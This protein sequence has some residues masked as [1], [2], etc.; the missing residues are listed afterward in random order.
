MRSQFGIGDDGDKCR[1]FPRA[2]LSYCGPRKASF[3][4][5]IYSMIAAG[6]LPEHGQKNWRRQVPQAELGTSCGLASR[7]SYTRRVSAIA[8]DPGL[9]PGAPAPNP[10]YQSPARYQRPSLLF[11]ARQFGAANKY[12][13]GD[14]AQAWQMERNPDRYQAPSSAELA[15]DPRTGHLFSPRAGRTGGFKDVPRWIFDARLPLNDTARM[16]LTYY[17]LCGLLESGEVHP[18]QATVAA[19]LGIT[20]RSVY[21]ANKALAALGLIRVAHPK[22][23][24]NAEGGMVRGPARIVYLPMRVLSAGEAAV[25]AKRLLDAHRRYGHDRFWNA[26]VRAHDA[27]LGAWM[28]HDHTLAAFR[29][30]IRRRLLLDAIPQQVLDDLIPSPPD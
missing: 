27:L 9:V 2:W 5:T 18:R 3:L 25:E 21:T 7:A 6:A 19:M 28:G 13:F 8:N 1:A 24:R 14:V 30:E 17:V 12:F 20:A 16:V 23:R 29:R 22:P 4:A 15:G 10:A 26:V 11:R